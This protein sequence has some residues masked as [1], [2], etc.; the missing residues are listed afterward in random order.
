[1]I[2]KKEDALQSIDILN[3][4]QKSDYD[5]RVL[6]HCTKCLYQPPYAFASNPFFLRFWK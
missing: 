3:D 2:E 5:M 1:M 4:M 6:Y